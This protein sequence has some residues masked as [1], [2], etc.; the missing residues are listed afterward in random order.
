M[1]DATLLLYIQDYLSGKISLEKLEDWIAPRLP[2]ISDKGSDI[3]TSI[4]DE[5]ELALVEI[6]AG[7]MEEEELKSKLKNI[8]YF[9]SVENI[10]FA[11]VRKGDVYFDEPKILDKENDKVIIS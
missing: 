9:Y 8:M 2:A 3:E 7:R 4:I 6:E 11:N 10:T 1:S 5:I